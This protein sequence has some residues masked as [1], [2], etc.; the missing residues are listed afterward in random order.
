MTGIPAEQFQGHVKLDAL[1]IDS[2][3]ATEIVSEVH[4]VFCISIPQ[5]HLQDLQTFMS[6]R[7]Y[8]DAR[9]ARGVLNLTAFVACGII[10]GKHF[11]HAWL[12][13]RKTSSH[14]DHDHDDH[15]D[16]GNSRFERCDE[17]PDGILRDDE[18]YFFVTEYENRNDHE[19]KYS[20]IPTF[21]HW[22]FPHENIPKPWPRLT[23]TLLLEPVTAS[24]V[25]P[26]QQ[27][28]D[29]VMVRDRSHR[30]TGY[31]KG[32]EV[33]YLLPRKK[34]T[35]FIDND[36]IRYSSAV[37]SPV[38]A[39]KDAPNALLLRSDLHRFFDRRRFALVPKGSKLVV[40]QMQATP[41]RE[42]HHLYHNRAVQPGTCGIAPQFLLAR[43]AWTVLCD[44][45]YT[46]LKGP[47]R[48]AITVWNPDKGETFVRIMSG[49]DVAAI[50]QI[51]STPA[52][53]RS[54]SPRK[55]KQ[56]DRAEGE[57]G[58][59]DYDKLEAEDTL[60]DIE[61]NCR[62]RSSNLALKKSFTTNFSYQL[63]RGIISR[64]R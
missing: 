56:D 17:P 2:L 35:W 8:L 50:S 55:R 61:E 60:S 37:P 5:D 62:G 53:S 10:A 52:K 33:D 21:D 54:M 13:Q 24:R 3:M 7:D 16:N 57:G 40:H 38:G 1:G 36:I 18:Y 64:K 34:G 46:F 41:A 47:Q 19:Y 20:V 28:N 22:R 27:W 14:T 31:Q 63:S 26:F 25:N 58:D 6:L 51:F 49:S 43:F 9:G 30:I 42:I 48:Y 23:S 44:E 11:R 4:D 29:I 32:C 12:G 39:V 59:D 15:N 45:N